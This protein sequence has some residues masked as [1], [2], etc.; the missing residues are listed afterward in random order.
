[1]RRSLEHGYYQGWDLH[2]AQ[3]PTRYAA[4]YAFYRDGLASAVDR[5]RRYSFEAEGAILD[6]PA[7]VRALADFLVRGLEC[8]A[9]G[10]DETDAT[11]LSRAQLTALARPVRS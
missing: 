3:L 10:D 1:V 8:G 7:T 6:E 4:T 11:G 5:L 9:L 2:L